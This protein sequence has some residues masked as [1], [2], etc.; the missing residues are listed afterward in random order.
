MRKVWALVLAGALSVGVLGAAQGAGKAAKLFTDP[1]GDA[2]VASQE[3]AIPGAENGGFDLTGGTVRRVGSNLEF[4][5]TVAAM[6]SNGALPE[7]FRYLHHFAVGKNQ[8][9]FTIKS[10]DIGKPDV[11]GQSGTERVGRIDTAGHFR[12]E[13]C[14]DQVVTPD[15]SPTT[16]TLVN[17]KAIAYLKGKF[18]P[19][20]KSFTAILPL[21][22]IKAKPGT[23]IAPGTSGAAASSCQVCW[24]P[25]YA[26][27]SLTPHTIIDFATITAKYKVPR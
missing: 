21:K 15:G 24:V 13:S 1:A 10:A 23:V 11:I 20:K 17:C 4:T 2:G 5:T 22:A 27:R 14:G 19:A 9:R 7:G 26:E 16:F 3:V 8:F 25:Q 18:D 12:L 6:P